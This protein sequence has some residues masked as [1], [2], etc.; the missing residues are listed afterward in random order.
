MTAPRPIDW[1][2]VQSAFTFAFA[3][4]GDQA[5]KGTDIPYV[6][7]LWGVASLVLEHGGHTDEVVAALLHDTAEDQGGEETAK[8]EE[9][10]PWHDRKRRYLA[11]LGE[12]LV[13][14]YES[15]ADDHPGVAGLARE[16]RAGYAALTALVD[17]PAAPR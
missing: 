8:G 16:L 13:K 7:H 14:A 11:S 5:R 6:A 2:S 15:R 12:E 9:K 17:E 1:E 10:P 3:E 4:H